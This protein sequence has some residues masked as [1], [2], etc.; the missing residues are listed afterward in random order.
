M[1]KYALFLSIIT[2]WLFNHA[3]FSQDLNSLK[4]APFIFKG[5]VVQYT[6]FKNDQNIW[7]LA[8][9][10]EIKSIYKGEDLKLDTVIL[11]AES[12]LGWSQTEDGPIPDIVSEYTLEEKNKFSFGLGSGTNRL[13]F[14][15]Q[16]K[17]NLKNIP[18]IPVFNNRIFQISNKSIILEPIC[19]TRDCY[20]SYYPDKKIV[21]NRAVDFLKIKGFGKEFNSEG[22]FMEYLKK[23]NIIS[24]IEINKKEDAE[25]IKEQSLK[26]TPTQTEDSIKRVQNKLLFEEKRKK[27]YEQYLEQRKKRKDAQQ[28]EKQ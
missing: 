4:D 1:K 28:K 21:N 18:E 16:Y 3:S 6:P 15:N 2:L 25:K 5:K 12:V 23:E 26:N 8:Y 7:M 9:A 13:F 14:C 27:N 22:E 20:F 11:I 10:I 19:K 17:N 24:H